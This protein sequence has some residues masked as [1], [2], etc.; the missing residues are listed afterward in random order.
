MLSDPQAALAP[1]GVEVDM[2]Q[3]PATRS[4]PSKET[5]ATASADLQA[6]SDGRQ[7]LVWL[8]LK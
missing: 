6:R 7:R 4:L 5:L 8:L 1:Y 3:L 2:S